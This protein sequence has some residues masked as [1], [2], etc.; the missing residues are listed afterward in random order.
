[1]DK[2]RLVLSFALLFLIVSTIPIILS[3]NSANSNLRK[4]VVEL[5]EE[6]RLLKTANLTAALGVIE[7][8]PRPGGILGSVYSHLWITGWV[9][10]SGWS[11][12]RHVGLNVLAFNETNGVFMNV[13]VPLDSRSGFAT[14]TKDY[15]VPK[16]PYWLPGSA[17]L[18]ELE[19]STILGQQNMT[20]RFSLYHEGS[21][22]SST[23]YEMN[24]IWEN[25]Q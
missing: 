9:F 8:P 20:V 13:T 11:M 23:R 7:V 2:I 6:I 12:A 14:A 19:Y 1:M 17:L 10:N 22:P 5:Q 25:P 15:L 24:P 4:Q 16:V 3:N 18:S 21:F